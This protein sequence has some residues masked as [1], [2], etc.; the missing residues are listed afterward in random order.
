MKETAPAEHL[1]FLRT[2]WIIMAVSLNSASHFR[3][4]TIFPGITDIYYDV[5][6]PRKFLESVGRIYGFVSFGH[7]AYFGIG[8]YAAAI[9]FQHFGISPWWGLLTGGIAA[10]D[11]RI[12]FRNCCLQTTRDP[13]L[14]SV[15]SL[16]PKF[17]EYLR[18]RRMA[19]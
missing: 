7:A 17:S 6:N 2:E 3:F 5:G 1:K 11:A 14:L 13:T 16:Q 15:L 19:D 8:A 9:P 4:L 12:S 10:V 18:R